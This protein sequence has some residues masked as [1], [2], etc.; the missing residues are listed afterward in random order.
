MATP[1]VT[2][3]IPTRDRWSLAT[4]AARCALEQRD[5][6]TEVIVVDDGSVER[7]PREGP[8]SDERVRVVRHSIPQGLG[9][10]RN[11]G[12]AEARTDWVA[13][14][15]DDDLWAPEKLRSQLR[16]ARDTGA[17]FAYCAAYLVDADLR[18]R[19]LHRATRVEALQR[20]LLEYNP[21]PAAGSNML[22]KREVMTRHGGFDETFHHLADWDLSL[23]LTDD[24]ICMA[25]LDDPLVAYTQH[26]GNMGATSPQRLVPEWRRFIRKHRALAR[27]RGRRFRSDRVIQWYVWRLQLGGRR[28][29]AA[30][31]GTAWGLRLRNPELLRNAASG[32]RPSAAARL[33][34]PARKGPPWLPE[35][36]RRREASWARAARQIERSRSWRVGS[37]LIR[38]FRLF[39]FRR[40][41]SPR[42]PAKLAAS[43]EEHIDSAVTQPELTETG[44][45][46]RR[47]EASWARA[48]RQIE[49]SRSWR[50]GSSLIRAFRLL[51]FRRPAS[52]RGPTRLAASIE[53]SHREREQSIPDES[54]RAVEIFQARGETPLVSIN[55]IFLDAE[56]F[57]EDAVESVLAQEYT[58][59]E[60]LLVD[61][62][63]TDRSRELARSFATHHPAIRYLEHPGHQ[64]LG[65]SASH[66]LALTRARGKYLAWLDSDDVWFPDTLS[67]LVAPLERNPEAAMAYGSTVWWHSWEHPE[68]PD[69]CDRTGNQVSHPNSLIRPPELVTLF[70]RNGGAVPCTCSVLFRTNAVHDV[71]GF[72]ESIRN[73]YVDQ[74][75][76]SKIFLEKPV[77]VTDATLSRYRQ[78]A[79]QT[80]MRADDAT[81]AAA[82]SRFLAWL[83][84]YVHERDVENDELHSALAIA[85][86][87][88]KWGIA[89]YRVQG[90]LG[91]SSESSWLVGSPGQMHVLRKVTAS[92]REYLEYQVMVVRHL[93][94]SDFPY[95][96]PT[97]VNP[98]GSSSYFVANG[99]SNWL[100]Y[101]F[102]EGGRH[103][104]P[105]D[106]SQATDLGIFVAH[107]DRVIETF[108]SGAWPGR[109]TSKLFDIPGT[110]GR[111]YAGAQWISAR[112]DLPNLRH[113]LLDN[114]DA[115]VS[116]CN[117]IS[118][119]EIEEAHRLQKVTIYNDWHP[120]N[121]V[122]RFGRIHGLVDFDSVVEA[123]RIVDFQNALTY[124]LI[125]EEF[126][127]DHDVVTGF[128]NGYCDV[129]PLSSL[130][131]SL[132]FPVMLDRIAWLI[133]RILDEIREEGTKSKEGLAIRLIELFS[134]LREHRERFLSDLT[135]I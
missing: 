135:A 64:N 118:G 63:S 117:V 98:G 16:V 124:A 22:V 112:Q 49:R 60:L 7:A 4:R 51:T 17:E 44:K 2:V 6:P 28:W 123:P 78:H 43:I 111:L 27:R 53:S 34:P 47:R 131:R 105:S 83:S 20:A 87:L 69:R 25:A 81:E 14:L 24:A 33:L 127:P 85:R 30:M 84:D 100:L 119:S 104:Q 9:A 73:S 72:E 116:A 107:Y 108:D 61:D 80:V 95:E 48:A 38:A 93:A 76:Y 58:N 46:Q 96:V 50:V 120:W 132:V 125:G 1:A 36:S 68:R 42:G 113:A 35:P 114:I 3:I 129:L 88:L 59:W 12:V 70:L 37:S 57:L 45:R 15:D 97:I 66:S 52:P 109:H 11:R 106:F 29:R 77:F 54:Q 101:R 122:S 91:G 56:R 90:K 102:I 103:H 13:F 41:A 5:V 134:W 79:D 130:E 23:R 8:L 10:A 110:I 55:M 86:V 75:L 89:G 99:G 92:D 71:G 133:T 94:S 62:G 19:T 18:V 65:K 39:T 126:R 26:A 21:I 121:I 74:A 40:P 115:I 31:T 32:L 82:R 67:R 128:V